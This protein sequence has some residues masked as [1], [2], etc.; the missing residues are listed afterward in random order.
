[1]VAVEQ[2]SLPTVPRPADHE[3]AR[4]EGGHAGVHLDDQARAAYKRRLLDID[5]DIEDATRHNDLGRIA[6]AQADREY[7]INELARAVGLGGRSRVAGATSER[8]R[9]SVTRS[10]RYAIKRIGEHHPRLGDH[11]QRTIDTGTYCLYEPDP[12][13][14][15]DWTA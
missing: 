8:A 5:E 9:T 4:H 1:L 2:G 14:P 15:T 10:L 3:A 13:A 12:R 7:L 11:L 6:L